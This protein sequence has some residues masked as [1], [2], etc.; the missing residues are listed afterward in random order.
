MEISV[1]NRICKL[2]VNSHRKWWLQQ[3]GLSLRNNI[4][5]KAICSNNNKYRHFKNRSSLY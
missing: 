3:S 2:Y 4:I 5:R 1:M